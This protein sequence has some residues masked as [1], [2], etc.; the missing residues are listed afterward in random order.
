MIII[1]ILRIRQFARQ[2]EVVSY[3]LV[4]FKNIFVQVLEM[5]VES[6]EEAKYLT[7]PEQLRDKFIPLYFVPFCTKEIDEDKR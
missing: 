2:D 1:V 6:E 5:S 7:M 3:K 4:Y